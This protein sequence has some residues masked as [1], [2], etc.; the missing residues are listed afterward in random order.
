MERNLYCWLLQPLHYHCSWH[1]CFLR[2][3]H[4]LCLKPLDYF[5][6]QY[7]YCWLSHYSSHYGRNVRMYKNDYD[8][9]CCGNNLHNSHRC[10]HC[11]IHCDNHSNKNCKPS[12]DHTIRR[13]G[14]HSSP[15]QMK[16]RNCNNRNCS[17]MGE[18]IL[19]ASTS[20]NPNRCLP[21]NY[22]GI[23]RTNTYSYN[24]D[25]NSSSKAH[26][27]GNDEYEPR[28]HSRNNHHSNN[29]SLH[30]YCRFR[31]NTSPMKN[32]STQVRDRQLL[33]PPVLDILQYTDDHWKKYIH[34]HN[35]HWILTCRQTLKPPT[36]PY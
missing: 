22:S 18:H 12:R 7:L 27:S 1:N 17:N 28:T 31:H 5:L 26:L 20:Y 32:A 8:H 9:N 16:N 2:N 13:S 36:R 33:Q 34:H 35:K 3:R 25:H 30:T 23:Y 21:Q 19:K 29:Y 4:L 11:D 24:M 15:M 6:F 14:N 10:I